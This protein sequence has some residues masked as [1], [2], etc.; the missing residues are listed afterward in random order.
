MFKKKQIIKSWETQENPKDAINE[1]IPAIKAIPEWYKKAPVIVDKNKTNY[2]YDGSELKLDLKRFTGLNQY[3]ETFKACTPMLDAMGLGYVI[4]TGEDI[5]FNEDTHSFNTNSLVQ[6]TTHIPYQLEGYPVPDWC[7][8]ML[9][10]WNSKI[11][12]ILPEGYTA[13]HMMPLHR[14][15]LPFYTLPGVIDGSHPLEVNTPFFMKKG[16]TGVIPEG[17]PI[18]QIIPFKIE[19]WKNDHSD[20]VKKTAADFDLLKNFFEFDEHMEP[21]A[22][23]YKKKIRK[24]KIFE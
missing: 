21:K 6:Q 7:H 19:D 18:I 1:I 15:D 20:D 22:G 14:T 4:V 17:T 23:M 3:G 2:N 24:R 9:F 5:Y 13:L 8:E 11:H 12:T 10:K 16:F